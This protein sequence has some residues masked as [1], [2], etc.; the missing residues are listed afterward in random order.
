MRTDGQTERQTDKMKLMVA[1]RN[2]ANAP[3]NFVSFNKMKK[4]KLILT[5]EAQVRQILARTINL[6]MK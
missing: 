6:K 2:F 3:K 4:N 1:C 5:T